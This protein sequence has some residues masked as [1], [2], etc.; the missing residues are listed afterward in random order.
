MVFSDTDIKLMRMEVNDS[1]GKTT[2]VRF[3]TLV[4]NKPLE[5]ELFV[6]PRVKA[7]LR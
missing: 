2:I 3:K 1:I 7:K 4:Y 6:L 5:K